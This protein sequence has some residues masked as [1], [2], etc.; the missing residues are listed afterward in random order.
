MSGTAKAACFSSP[1]P[2]LH[3]VPLVSQGFIGNG[4][5]QLRLLPVSSH[6]VCFS[7][8]SRLHF[9]CTHVPSSSA[10][11]YSDHF[12]SPISGSD[13]A[14]SM[15]NMLNTQ[16]NSL[17]KNLT[18][19]LLVYNNSNSTR[20]DTLDSS[21]FA[22]A[23]FMGHSFLNS[24]HSLGIYSITLPLQLHA[25]DYQKDS[26]FSKS[27]REHAPGVSPPS[28]CLCLSFGKLLED[29]SLSK[30]LSPPFPHYANTTEQ[31]QQDLL[32]VKVLWHLT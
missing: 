1:G 21:S 4:H 32:C 9:S 13:S 25:C 8:R 12:P 14:L 31:R 29:G 6:E 10:S 22:M 23:T 19:H 28:L 30:K 2:S 18:F 24:T 15:L 11:F 27:S 7:D 5:L 3:C 17:G 16:S 26:M 20:S